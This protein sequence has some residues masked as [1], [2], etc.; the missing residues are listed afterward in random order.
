MKNASKYKISRY[1]EFTDKALEI[2]F[3]N[4]EIGRVIKYIKLITLILGI[5]FMLFIIPD[6]FLIKNKNTLFIIF[7]IR[8]VVLLL[9][10]ILFLLVGNIKN[11]R[12][13]AVGITALEMIVSIAFV[14]TYYFYESPD[15]L[16]QAM[17]VIII[18]IGIYLAPNKWKNM[19]IAAI[20]VSLV[21]FIM[22]LYFAKEMDFSDFSAGIV[23][24]LIVMILSSIS[25][26]RT[27]YYKRAQY[28]DNRE[29][30]RMSQTDF[31]TGLYNRGKFNEELAK[32]MNCSTR[33]GTPLSMAIFDFDDF[34]LINDNYGHLVG[35]NVII[36]T[37]RIVKDTI[38]QTDIFARWGGEE[39][40]LL[41]PNTS[42]Q[43]A[44][45]LIERLRKLIASHTYEVGQEVTCSFGLV[46]LGVDE[47]EDSILQR[48]DKFLYKA[49][50]AGKNTIAC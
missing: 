39:F 5:L 38:R 40:T 26:F 49:K 44:K 35:D 15:Y 27:S 30:L 29:L 16:I 37:V 50:A 21:F 9:I 11:Y 1:G 18:I 20:T 12:L 4:Y 48:A 45:E 46:T 33:F 41:L 28:I 17:G 6:Y 8:A 31:L 32:W 2:D 13:Y 25:S 34:K 43:Q 10:L 19:Q 23:Y 47:T 36:D 14:A 7:S 22:S 3:F 24:I 42:M